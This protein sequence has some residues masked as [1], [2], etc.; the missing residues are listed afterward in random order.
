MR[1]LLVAYDFPPVPSP[2]SLRWAYLARELALLGHEVH[3]LAPDIEGYGS[4]GL[5]VLADSL[6]VHRAWP[7]PLAG[8]LAWHQRRRRNAEGGEPAGPGAGALPSSVAASPLNWKGKLRRRVDDA[9]SARFG[10]GLNWKGHAIEA[11]KRA[12]SIPLFPDSRAEWQ[13]WAKRRLCEL[14]DQYRPDVVISSHEPAMTIELGALAEKKGYPWVADLGD[15]VLAPYTPRRWRG[16]AMAT[17]RMLCQ[18]ASLVT[19]TSDHAREVLRERHGIE[20]E[21]CAILTQGFDHRETAAVD[22]PVCFEEGRLELVYTGSFYSFRRVGALLDAVLSVPP[23]RLTV[24]TMVAPPELV[25]AA[26]RHP[27]RIRLLGF[28]H[29]SQALA[30]QRSCDV[31]VNL[32]NASPVQVPGKFFEYLGSG[33][34]ILHVG[35]A[36]DDFAATLLRRS[37]GGW[38]EPDDREILQA[39]ILALAEGKARDGR[40]SGAA[41]ASFDVMQYSWHNLALRLVGLISSRIQA[42]AE[43]PAR[44]VTTNAGTT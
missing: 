26:R 20:E 24:A 43:P 40:V 36:E 7:G 22:A 2:Q 37:G 19:V 3:V 30:L 16:R 41:E 18:R 38:C 25:A 33:T 10:H 42:P 32:A 27:D 23:A 12:M 17:E 5:P 11:I 6:T 15:P 13:P 31:L 14:L 39:R 28:V 21:R 4:G 29:H 9:L 1:L 44:P 35:G 34:P 8:F